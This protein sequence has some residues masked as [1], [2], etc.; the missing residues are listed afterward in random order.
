[1]FSGS[2]LPKP[3]WTKDGKPLRGAVTD[4][5]P[6]LCKIKL[7]KVKRE[8][9]GEYELELVNPIG[10]EKV[11]I[12]LKVIGRCSRSKGLGLKFSETWDIMMASIN[13]YSGAVMLYYFSFTLVFTIIFKIFIHIVLSSPCN[14]P[15]NPQNR[16]LQNVKQ[17]VLERFFEC[18]IVDKPSKPEGPLDITDVYKDR[19]RLQWKP[20]KDDGGFPIDNYIVEAMDTKEGTWAEVGKVQGDTQC[21][22]PGLKPG[23]KYKFRVKAVN[24]EGVSEPLTA[25]RETLAKDPWGRFAHLSTKYSTCRL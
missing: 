14:L 23:R 15:Q 12:T 8:D 2:P 3:S 10:K 1:M 21:G 11:P 24:R 17:T 13:E 16:I 18:D 22:V 6:D 4:Q 19:C 7:K 9:E 20:P 5:T 25:D